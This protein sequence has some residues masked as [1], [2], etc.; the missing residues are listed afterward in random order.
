MENRLHAN[1]APAAALLAVLA[2]PAAA[3]H[4]TPGVGPN[5]RYATD[6]YPGFDNE[7]ETV[8][9]ERKEPRWFSFLTGPKRGSPREQIEYCAEL[10]AERDY[11][12]ARR[13]LDALV[14]E[15]PTSPEAPKAQK[16]LADLCLE[17]LLDYEDAFAEY[18]YLLDFY[19]LQCDYNRIADKM[20]QVA[21]LMRQ[22]GKEVMFI[23]FANTVDVRRA[24]EACVLH[25]PGASWA[26][27]AMLV[28]GALREDEGK[29]GEAAKVYENLRN[30]HHDSPEAAVALVREAEAR[31]ALLRERAYNRARSRETADFLVSALRECRP[32]DAGRLRGHLAEVRALMEDEAYRGAKF[33][34]SPTRTVRSAVNAYERFLAEYPDSARAGEVR[35]RL[36]ELKGSGR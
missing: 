21:G 22:E 9:P 2:L 30:T 36:D 6:A 19:S 16:A 3:D 18:R 12:K 15:W 29:F 7:K 10:M 1:L 14:R 32:G 27:E 35:A 13:Q 11:P 31:M 4:P 34:D 8:S 24:Y 17:N 28:I 23:R 33:Y 25:A 26:P 20:Y 5:A